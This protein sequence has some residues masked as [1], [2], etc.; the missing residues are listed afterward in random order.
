VDRF[1]EKS[2][3]LENTTRKRERWVSCLRKPHLD[4]MKKREISLEWEI[5]EFK[6]DWNVERGGSVLTPYVGTRLGREGKGRFGEKG[7][8]WGGGG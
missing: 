3:Q 7:R 2:L 5:G 1:A 8:E 4:G 6:R